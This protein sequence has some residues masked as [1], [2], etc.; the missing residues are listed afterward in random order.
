MASSGAA[1]DQDRLFCWEQVSKTNGLFRISRVFAPRECA[2]KLLPL[3]A[4]FSAIEFVSS[5]LTDEDVAASKLNWWRS[6]CLDRDMAESQ[7]PLVRELNRTGAAADLPREGIA[8]LLGGAAR[9]SSADAPTDM[10]ALRRICIETAT[11]QLELELAV[12]AP[13]VTANDLNPGAQARNGLLQLVR[14][15]VA[16]NE[17]HA[18]WWVPL[19]SLARHGVSR[20]DIRNQPG[21]AGVVSLLSEVLEEGMSWGR[22][23]GGFETR[24]NIDFSPARHVFA[25]NALYERKLKRLATCRPEQFAAELPRLRLSDLLAAWAGARRAG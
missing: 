7:H 9:R 15:S 18:F 13:D 8:R 21:L 4:F 2:E 5:R 17:R 12:S 14:E 3:Y 22:S 1:S 25:V 10:G 20:A 6:E 23:Q 24:S 16:G 19:N 11:P